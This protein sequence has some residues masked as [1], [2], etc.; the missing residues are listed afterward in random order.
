M[1]AGKNGLWLSSIRLIINDCLAWF[2]SLATLHGTKHVTINMVQVAEVLSQQSDLFL[3]LLGISYGTLHS[4]RSLHQVTIEAVH[5]FQMV[6]GVLQFQLID[7]IQRAQ[8][9]GQDLYL[10][11]ELF[12]AVSSGIE[13]GD[14]IGSILVCAFH[15]VQGYR[16]FFSFVGI[17]GR[18]GESTGYV[19]DL[20]YGRSEF[21]E[22]FAQVLQVSRSDVS[23]LQHLV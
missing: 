7:S 2:L 4:F 9:L 1:R 22:T 10:R 20:F 8:V 12:G 15:A 23:F 3:S 5:C 14:S 17:V 11:M 16:S 6:I 13:A 18:S 21:L 19:T